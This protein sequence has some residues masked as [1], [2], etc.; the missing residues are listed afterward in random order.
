M[1]YTLPLQAI[2]GTGTLTWGLATGSVLPPGLQI[3][4]SQIA[5]APSSAGAFA[6]T[7][8]LTDQA[9][10]VNLTQK[11]VTLVIEKGAT[12]ATLTP[13]STSPVFGE[14][15]TLT[16]ALSPSSG[17][18]GSVTFL[19]GATSMGSAPIVSG[20]ASLAVPAT[21]ADRRACLHRQLPG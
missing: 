6:F 1:P 10:P 21:L 3:V 20:V 11:D 5:G 14:T 2:G 12:A 9:T 8:E 15:V 18:T 7:L 4:G 17:P 13:S 16:V 19:D